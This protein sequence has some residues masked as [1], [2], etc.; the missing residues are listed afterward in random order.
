MESIFPHLIILGVVILFIGFR[1]RGALTT[2]RQR[3][4][5]RDKIDR[6]VP[7]QKSPSGRRTEEQNS[8]N[9]DNSKEK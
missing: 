6:L 3:L 1:F 8:D 9:T 7:K 5:E 2:L 4:D